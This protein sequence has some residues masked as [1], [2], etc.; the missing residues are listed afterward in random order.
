MRSLTRTHRIFI[1][2]A[3]LVAALWAAPARAQFTA[4]VAVSIDTLSSVPEQGAD[5]NPG[6]ISFGQTKTYVVTIANA[7]GPNQAEGVALE[8][9]TVPPELKLKTISGCVPQGTVSA[10]NPLGLPCLVL[11]T[12]NVLG[13]ILYTDSAEIDVEVQLPIPDPT[14]PADPL[15]GLA[16]VCPASTPGTELTATTATITT[17]ST[18]PTP[19]D[20]TATFVNTL[21]KWADLQISMTAPS[22]THIGGTI[23]VGVDVV[24]AGPCPAVA[25]EAGD[26]NGPDVWTDLNLV[27]LGQEGGIPSDP[28]NTTLCDATAD[29]GYGCTIGDLAP[30]VHVV[31]TMHFQLT[32]LPDTLTQSGVPVTTQ[33]F[34]GGRTY[35]STS[36]HNKLNRTWDPNEGNNKGRTASIAQRS[37]KS[38]STGGM[39]DALSLL[40]LALP[41]A[42]RRRRKA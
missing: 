31:Y 42:L 1:G 27:F 11:G 23:D 10:S 30:D 8:T 16:K 12:N 18:D 40:A 39:G 19:A 22:H 2:G 14:D 17:T 25:V 41:F 29:V 3:A 37:Q 38:C 13:E 5:A 34:S 36:S 32:G 4:D 7:V 33:V 26:L 9:F 20:N 35:Y 15:S 28:A 24:N 6:Q 21:G